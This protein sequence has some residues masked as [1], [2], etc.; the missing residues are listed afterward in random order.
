MSAVLF[1]LL[2][3]LLSV[4][5][6]SAV[7]ASISFFSFEVGRMTAYLIRA[8]AFAPSVIAIYIASLGHAWLAVLVCTAS[9]LVNALIASKCS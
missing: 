4:Q 8:I 9:V 6:V 5:L 2:G 7:F 1:L 3:V